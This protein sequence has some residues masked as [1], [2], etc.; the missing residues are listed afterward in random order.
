MEGGLVVKSTLDAE[1]K[2]ISDEIDGLFLKS[3]FNISIVRLTLAFF[4]IMNTT[5]FEEAARIL[6]KEG[7]LLTKNQLTTVENTLVSKNYRK[8]LL[9]DLKGLICKNINNV[10]NN[11]LSYYIE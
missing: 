8:T 6:K 10:I 4:N 2:K 3:D 11:D 7:A 1:L 9:N 5:N